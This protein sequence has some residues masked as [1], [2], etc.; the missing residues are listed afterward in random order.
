VS[1]SQFS[2]IPVFTTPLPSDSRSEGDFNVVS[3][4]SSLSLGPSALDLL[5]RSWPRSSHSTPDPCPSR[6]AFAAHPCPTLQ[7]L[8]VVS[9]PTAP[10]SAL[11]PFLQDPEFGSPIDYEQVAPQLV[12]HS[13]IVGHPVRSRPVSP[14]LQYPS[15][16]PVKRTPTLCD[17]LPPRYL[18]TPS[19]DSE[20]ENRPPPLVRP[21]FFQVPR[22]RA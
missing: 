5:V 22:V 16:P 1:F 20:V 15:P 18:P 19:Y 21:S 13:P 14:D 12:P 6:A 10:P 4:V 7:P 9:S 17:L 11:F 2:S 8:T 3:P